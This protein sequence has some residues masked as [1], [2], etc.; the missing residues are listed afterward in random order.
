[1]ARYSGDTYDHPGHSFVNDDDTIFLFHPIPT[2]IDSAGDYAGLGQP[3]NN[4]EVIQD[5]GVI[6]GGDDNGTSTFD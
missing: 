5:S 6:I 3:Y 2:R 1:V 4:G